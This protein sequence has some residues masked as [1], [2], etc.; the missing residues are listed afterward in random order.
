MNTIEFHGDSLN[1]PLIS[2]TLASNGGAFYPQDRGMVQLTMTSYAD[3]L[4]QDVSGYMWEYDS[5][6]KT[7]RILDTAP[8]PLREPDVMWQ[9]MTRMNSNFADMIIHEANRAA[10]F[11]P[12]EIAFA[13]FEDS[14][15]YDAP[16]SEEQKQA[17]LDKRI[18]NEIKRITP[19]TKDYTKNQHLYKQDSYGHWNHYGDMTLAE[20][21]QFD[22]EK[23]QTLQEEFLQQRIA[24]K[25]KYG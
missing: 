11:Y 7:F 12:S 23:Q 9:A 3:N 13:D 21:I 15:S 10:I 24:D 8:V 2:Y 25:V 4:W 20:I 22:L 14:F 16:Q 19:F 17:D 6:N 5:I 1:E 18:I